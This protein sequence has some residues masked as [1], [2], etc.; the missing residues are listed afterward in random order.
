MHWSLLSNVKTSGRF[1]PKICGLF[2]G[3]PFRES[4]LQE[5]GLEMILLTQIHILLFR[6]DPQQVQNLYEV[7]FEYLYRGSPDSTVFTLPGNRT[8]EKTVLFVDWFST[9]ITIYD[10]WI[11]KVPFFSSFSLIKVPFLLIINPKFINFSL[12]LL[13]I[14]TIGSWWASL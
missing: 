13:H 14:R 7:R 12:Y 2:R 5:Y 3:L 10:F 8:F 11:F 1:F 4:E 9:K 6:V